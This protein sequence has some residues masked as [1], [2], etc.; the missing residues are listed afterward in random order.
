MFDEEEL[1]TFVGICSELEK[2]L[3]AMEA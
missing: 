3:F 2:E 1:E